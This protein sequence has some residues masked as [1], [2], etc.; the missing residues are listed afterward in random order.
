MASDV[1][2]ECS[3]RAQIDRQADLSLHLRLSHS[4][5]YDVTFSEGSEVTF[6]RSCIHATFFQA[7]LYQPGEWFFRIEQFKMPDGR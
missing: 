5:V 6:A 3:S 2:T 7:S 1:S 4:G